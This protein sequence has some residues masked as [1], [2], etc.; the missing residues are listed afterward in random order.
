MTLCDS[1]AARWL[2]AAQNC[3]RVLYVIAVAVAKGNPYLTATSANCGLSFRG[4]LLRIFVTS[5]MW[6]AN[7]GSSCWLIHFCTWRS[8]WF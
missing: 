1:Q 7:A 4:R 8:V 6:A 3:V 2:A 5:V